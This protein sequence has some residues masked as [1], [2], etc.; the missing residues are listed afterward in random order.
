MPRSG[1]ASSAAGRTATETV[2][3]APGVPCRSSATSW[4]S[5]CGSGASPRSTS[6]STTPPSGAPACSTCSQELESGR[7]A[8]RDRAVRRVAAHAGQAA[9]PRGRRGDPRRRRLG[10]GRSPSIPPAARPRA[11]R[12]R[13][14][15][16]G[17][18]ARSGSGAHRARA[19]R[20]GSSPRRKPG[21]TEGMSA[22]R[23]PVGFA[24]DAVPEPVLARIRA[25]RHV[26]AVSHENP[27][28]DTLGAVLGHLPDRRGP[29]RSRDRRLHG[30]GAAA[31]RL[32]ARDR[33]VPHGPGPG[34]RPTT[35]SSSP[36]ARRPSGWARWPAR[37][38]RACS[39]RC[40]G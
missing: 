18:R 33:P 6:T 37:Q 19:R 15:R 12:R 17:R 35:C 40:R 31:L 2:A 20:R 24:R 22:P 16:T 5:A 8:R 26:L 30:S 27:D 7:G 29:G 1:S 9:A 28:A 13:R 38:R 4:A 36:T 34:A 32:H 23:G 25:A 11:G 3:R 10:A 39:R 21:S 14:S